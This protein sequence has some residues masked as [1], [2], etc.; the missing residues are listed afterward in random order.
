MGWLA[1]L[2]LVASGLKTAIELGKL[3]E[4]WVAEGVPDEEIR[5]RLA[6]PAGVGQRVIDEARARKGRFA[7]YKRNG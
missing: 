5:R 1:A 4:Q 2:G 6:D 3:V 7:D